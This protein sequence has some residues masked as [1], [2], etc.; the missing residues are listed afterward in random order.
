MKKIY[1]GM[2]FGQE[3]YLEDKENIYT[4]KEWQQKWENY[5]GSIKRN[6]VE[7]YKDGLFFKQADKKIAE[8]KKGFWY[9]LF[10]GNI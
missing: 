10:K 5:I 6:A 2:F 8:L 7:E 9:N 4:E 1:L 3:L